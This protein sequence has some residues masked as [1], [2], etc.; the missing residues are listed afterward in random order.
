[1]PPS[2]LSVT[3]SGPA[4]FAWYSTGSTRSCRGTPVLA[5]QYGI[6]TADD[7]ARADYLTQGLVIVHTASPAVSTS[8]GCFTGRP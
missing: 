4:G 3:G 8:E 7:D 1:M 5:A 2:R 6:K